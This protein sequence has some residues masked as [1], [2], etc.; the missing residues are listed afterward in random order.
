[1]SLRGLCSM[2]RLAIRGVGRGRNEGIRMIVGRACTWMT[3]TREVGVVSASRNV[4]PSF[5]MRKSCL[6]ALG[7]SLTYHACYL[8]PHPV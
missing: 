7:A 4:D 8:A 3:L 6:L 1:M 2:V 5:L